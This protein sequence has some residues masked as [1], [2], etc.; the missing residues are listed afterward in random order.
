MLFVFLLALVEILVQIAENTQS[1]NV[2]Y[3]VDGQTVGWYR[4]GS[5]DFSVNH[6]KV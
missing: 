6:D 5:F 2:F 3:M 1:H 4:D